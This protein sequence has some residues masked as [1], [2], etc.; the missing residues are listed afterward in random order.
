MEE[1]RYK[2]YCHK[3]KANGFEYIGMTC[4]DV[5]ARWSG[6]ALSYANCKN[7]EEALEKYGWDGF[8]HIVLVSG[9]TKEEAKA[10]ETELIRKNIAAGISYNI[11][12]DDDF[13]V[14]LVDGICE[15]I[16]QVGDKLL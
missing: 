11:R 3:N 10:K 14:S 8:D 5:R 9:L 12:E 4:R 1:K 2:V 7:F 16:A 13:L 6:K 15:L